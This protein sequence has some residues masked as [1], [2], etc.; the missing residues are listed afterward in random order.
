M[1]LPLQADKSLVVGRK[2]FNS[3]MW[4]NGTLEALTIVLM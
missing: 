3:L 1:V 2:L 4:F